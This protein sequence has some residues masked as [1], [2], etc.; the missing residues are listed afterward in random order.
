M[1][2]AISPRQID[3]GKDKKGPVDGVIGAETDA[4]TALNAAL[5]GVAALDTVIALME[6]AADKIVAAKT[7]I[8]EQKNAGIREIENATGV[9]KT[10]LFSW[11][12]N[13]KKEITR[14]AGTTVVQAVQDNIQ[15]IANAVLE[16]IARRGYG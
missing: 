1:G 7:E 11:V 14:H 5:E 6:Q 8:E 13:A 15:T 9:G 10:E 4:L 2:I 16:E 12:D 3:E